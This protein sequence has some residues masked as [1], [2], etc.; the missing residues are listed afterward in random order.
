[1][2]TIDEI[3]MY[4]NQRA[5]KIRECRRELRRIFQNDCVR[6][7]TFTPLG[8]REKIGGFNKRIL[9]KKARM[10]L[11]FSKSNLPGL[12]GSGSYDTDNYSYCGLADH[13]CDMRHD[14]YL[15][16]IEQ[17]RMAKEMSC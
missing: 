12:Y 13:H 15:E 4:R 14:A 2:T 10:N 6:G 3:K 17:I 5:R 11:N 1:M 9:L 16:A 8:C 7:F